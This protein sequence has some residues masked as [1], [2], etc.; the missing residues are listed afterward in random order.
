[1]KK[2]SVDKTDSEKTIMLG[3]IVL[4]LFV[5]SFILTVVLLF[6]M[7]L[8]NVRSIIGVENYSKII[9]GTP[10]IILLLFLIIT[11]IIN[12]RMFKSDEVLKKTNKKWGSEK[13]GIFA[14]VFIFLLLLIKI[15]GKLP[16]GH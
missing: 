2:L 4:T 1:M 12:N 9:L 10:F 15:F 14:V 3:K 7:E 16:N 8:Y 6:L 13:L 5:L 11:I